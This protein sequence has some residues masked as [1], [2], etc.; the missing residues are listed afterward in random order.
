MTIY[1]KD[2]LHLLQRNLRVKDT[3]IFQVGEETFVY[4]VSYNGTHL[5][6]KVDDIANDIIFR[7]LGIPN[8]HSF[9]TK[10][11][12]RSPRPGTCFP[13]S[14]AH[15]LKD[16]LIDLENIICALFAKCA[17]YN[18]EAN[19]TFFANEDR[20]QE[21]E[22]SLT[23]DS[24]QPTSRIECPSRSFVV[25]FRPISYKACYV[26]SRKRASRS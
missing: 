9:A 16:R 23:R 4:E 13:E 14:A 21:K 18:E 3:I 15:D 17:S 10:Y 1:T 7:K 12:S 20:L 6:N 19:K 5:D 24:G 2:N 26:R 11:Y 25:E 22:I 8:A